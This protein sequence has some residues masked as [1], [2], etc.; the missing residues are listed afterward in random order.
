MSIPE[1]ISWLE[2]KN[3]QIGSSSLTEVTWREWDRGSSQG[4]EKQANQKSRS[5]L[6]F[7]PQSRCSEKRRTLCNKLGKFLKPSDQEEVVNLLRGKNGKYLKINS[8]QTALDVFLIHLNSHYS[9]LKGNWVGI[10]Y[11]SARSQWRHFKT[12]KDSNSLAL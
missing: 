1:P 4:K 6:L 8:N 5:H 11:L 3:P 7:S 9:N 2:K 12:F 10:S